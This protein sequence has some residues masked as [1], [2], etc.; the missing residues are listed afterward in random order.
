MAGQDVQRDNY[1]W[2]QRGIVYEIY[3]RSFRDTNGDGIGDLRGI[4]SRLDYLD[5]LGV[6][7]L[8]LGPIYPSPM[9]DF[10]YDVAD[11]F[12]VASVFG[13]MQDFDDL[14]ENA[15]RRGMRIILDYVPNHTSSRHPWF[16]ES[17]SSIDNPKRD[18]Y[19]WR[20]PA[21][22]GGPPNNW[23]NQF[24]GSAWTFDPATGQYYCHSFLPQQPDLNWRNPDVQASMLEV[25]RFWF[26]HGIDGWRIDA[27]RHLIKDDQFRNDP[28]NPHYV[29]SMGP[30]DSLLHIYSAGRPEV[31]EIAKRMRQV[32]DEF[33]Q[34]VLIGELYL[35]VEQLVTYYGTGGRG[36]QLPLNFQLILLPWNA[37]VICRAIQ[38]Y[39]AA[40]PVGAWPN[41]VL[42]N[43]DKSRISSRLGQQQARVAAMM[44]LTLRGTPTMYYG[45]EIGMCDLDL[46]LAA[47]RD[48]F[49][50]RLPGLRLGRDPQRAPMQWGPGTNAEFDGEAKPWLPVSPDYP[51][52][53]V[54]LQRSDDR[55]LLELYHRLIR[56]RRSHPALSV[57]KYAWITSRKDTLLYVRS[58]EQE[59][60]LMALNLSRKN[61]SIELPGL[62][63]NIL[64]S[65]DTSAPVALS[66][67]QLQLRG[68]EGVIIE[69]AGRPIELAAPLRPAAIAQTTR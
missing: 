26:R 5:W 52:R 43:H 4:I 53:N 10:G 9:A 38:K 46:P 22:D 42:G 58:H 59:Q 29:P 19:I 33:P 54:A 7:A 28:P 61:Q 44:L 62:R 36:V 64:M 32:A 65:T 34:T 31:H 48:P 20:D 55:S 14:V 69:L 35:P 11:Y 23:L 57:G 24:G 30:Y 39:E 60:L 21:P 63:G 41:W 3:P 8:W 40:L 49:G 15:H 18:W 50:K 2:W 17:C 1:R 51:H 6:D 47:M 68:D 45:D 12:G 67:G 27:L 16:Q 13:T 56:L 37:E 25:M 66:S